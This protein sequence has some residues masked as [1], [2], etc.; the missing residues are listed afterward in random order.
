MLQ[1]IAENSK[2][3]DPSSKKSEEIDSNATKNVPTK[4]TFELQD[5]RDLV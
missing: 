5:K 2:K 4:N 3:N 1:S